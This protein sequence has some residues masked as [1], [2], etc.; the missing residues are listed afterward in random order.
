MD[1]LSL[2]GAALARNLEELEVINRLLGGN[3]V[4]L[5][6]LH[7]LLKGRRPED[8]PLQIVDLG[9]GGGDL[10][11]TI[12]K[13]ARK[14]GLAVQITGIDANPFMIG[15]SQQKAKDFPE[16]TFELAD[17]W[18]PEFQARQFDLAICSLFCHHFSA[19]ELIPLFRQMHRQTRMGF[20][21]N[22]LH[23]HPLAYYSIQFLTWLFRGS[24]L[25]RHDAPL[26]VLRAFSRR[27][28]QDLLSSSGLTRYQLK[29]KW[30][31]RFQLIVFPNGG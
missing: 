10:P 25:V 5:D 1:D 3:Q 31:F 20:I 11:R 8:G 27:E 9:T 15:F 21:I 28:L 4:V 24:Y 2:E 23:R 26:S 30:A 19:D 12:V 16:I 17:L 18:S 7:Q 22:D 29:W 14:R 13:W 6:A